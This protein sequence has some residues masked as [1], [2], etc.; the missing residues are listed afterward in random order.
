MQ[1]VKKHI[2]HRSN[3]I[4]QEYSIKLY[5]KDY[6]DKITKGVFLRTSWRF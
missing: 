6:I 4:K 5:K 2:F 1:D 3:E